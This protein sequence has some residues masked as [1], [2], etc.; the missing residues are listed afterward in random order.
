MSAPFYT[1]PVKY[2][3]L[4]LSGNDYVVGDIHGRYDLVYQ[5]LSKVNFNEKTD[6]LFCV[7]DLIDRGPYSEHVLD[8]LQLPFVYAIRG[9]HEDILLEL[10]QEVVPSDQKIAYYGNQIGLNWWLNVAT[11][12]RLKIIEALR[13]LPLVMQI[14]TYRG[15]VGL[16][17]A[18][19]DENLTW[20]EFKNA[21]NNGE[22]HV[23]QEA[24]WGRKRLTHN[25]EK[26][27]EGIDRI[28]VGHT[29]QDYVKKLANVVAIDTGAVF[30]RHLTIAELPVTTQLIVKQNEETDN[31]HVLKN[32]NKDFPAFGIYTSSLKNKL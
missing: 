28:Y 22:D 25:I 4:N 18:D 9:N 12:K 15:S 17:H 11:E 23:I 30:N 31:V 27:V 1:E 16:V 8:F 20:E 29:V 2:F 21:I 5:A 26:A 13:Q 3:D 32:I 10:Y 19:I 6:R 14:E 24:L 7:G